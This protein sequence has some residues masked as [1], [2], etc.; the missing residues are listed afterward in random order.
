M[1]RA[2]ARRILIVE[3]EVLVALN[4]ED[5]LT[6][7]GHCV[8]ACA[9]RLDKAMQLATQADIDLAFLDINLG[10]ETSFSAAAILRRRNIP[11]VFATGYGTDGLSD[12]F[13]DTPTLQKPYEPRELR[14]AL[15]E[16]CARVAD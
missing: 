10:G 5:L 11:F 9:T 12:E 16:A 7:M 15:T 8:V 1:A 4:L 6:G 14:R 13:R 2:E 3:D